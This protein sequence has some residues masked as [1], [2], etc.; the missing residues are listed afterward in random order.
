M[1]NKNLPCDEPGS[2][3]IKTR[4]LLKKDKRSALDIHKESGVPFWWLN[5]F[6]RGRDG[7]DVNRIQFLYEFLSGKKLKV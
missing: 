1:P 6:L 4:E 5:D 7:S 2:L 3:L